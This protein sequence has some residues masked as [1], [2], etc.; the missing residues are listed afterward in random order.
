MA[1]Y[2]PAT[3][4]I[5]VSASDSDKPRYA[6]RAPRILSLVLS[7]MGFLNIT[8]GTV[9][10]GDVRTLWYNKDTDTLRRYNPLTA[11]WANITPP[12]FFM[13]ILQ[14]A[15]RAANVEGVMADD[16]KVPFFDVSAD[17]TKMISVADF[18]ASLGV[19]GWVQ[20]GNTIT[21]GAP[22]SSVEFDLPTTYESFLIRATFTATVGSPAYY[23]PRVRG[24][25][26]TNAVVNLAGGL[27]GTFNP[28]NTQQRYHQYSGDRGDLTG[29]VF[30]HNGYSY[31]DM[32]TNADQRMIAIS[33]RLA[34][35]RLAVPDGSFGD[36]TATSWQFA[37]GSVFKLFVR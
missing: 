1:V 27:S 31:D 36:E 25:Y 4:K 11:A 18:K 12:Q 7:Y 34:K 2:N 29:C 32:Q 15:F 20:W 22:A 33:N 9:A 5:I 16:D 19:T 10:P 6:V 26:P 21:L 30:R 14:T 17:E 24:V 35:V 13:H 3:Q 28:A 8:I 23:N 37:I